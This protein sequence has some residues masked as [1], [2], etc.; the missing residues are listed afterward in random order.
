MGASTQNSSPAQE[1]SLFGGFALALT[2]AITDAVHVPL[3][4]S[5]S[6]EAPIDCFPTFF[7]SETYSTNSTEQMSTE[8]NN[9]SDLGR[10]YHTSCTGDALVTVQAHQTEEDITLFGSCFCPFVQ[11]VWVA[12]EVLK[13]PYKVYILI[14]YH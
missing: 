5:A 12:F 1:K 13:V 8:V 7:H 11:R 3:D 10:I 4:Q 2:S 9:E 6:S 14:I